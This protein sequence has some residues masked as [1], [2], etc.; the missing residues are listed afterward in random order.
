M[1]DLCLLYQCALCHNLVPCAAPINLRLVHRDSRSII[2]DWD[3][4]PVSS[5]N[6]VLH[7]YKVEYWDKRHNQ[8][9]VH[10]TSDD[11][12][13]AVLGGLSYNTE[14]MIRVAAFTGSGSGDFSEPILIET[15]KCESSFM[16]F[17]NY[18]HVLLS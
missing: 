14:Y 15:K 1:V 4:I 12:F 16:D 8:S 6:G 7:G 3:P 9:A 17:L 11:E 10:K 13:T 18:F 2:V 5:E